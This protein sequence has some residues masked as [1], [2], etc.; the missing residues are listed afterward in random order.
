M[1]NSVKLFLS[2]TGKNRTLLVSESDSKV[3]VLPLE[4]IFKLCETDLREVD[5]AFPDETEKA[6]VTFPALGAEQ[7]LIR[8]VLPDFALM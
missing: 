4:P 2:F 6:A 7:E 3:R 5:Y 8:R 1:A